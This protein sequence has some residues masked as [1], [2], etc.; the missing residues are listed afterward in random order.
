MD[1]IAI[2]LEADDVFFLWPSD[3]DLP[4]LDDLPDGI[5]LRPLAEL[6]DVDETGA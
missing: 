1:L 6:E 3:E 2:V 4:D 5:E